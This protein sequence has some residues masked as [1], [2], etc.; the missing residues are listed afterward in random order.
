MTN[1]L[2]CLHFSYLSAYFLQQKKE[3]KGI[4]TIQPG[5]ADRMY[6]A[7][8]SQLSASCSRFS[9]FWDLCPWQQTAG[10]AEK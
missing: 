7:M 9:E 10:N 6:L 8:S 3:K 4:D 2:G 5:R 1:T